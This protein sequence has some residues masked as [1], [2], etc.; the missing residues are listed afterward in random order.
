MIIDH[1]VMER[2]VAKLG[3]LFRNGNLNSSTDFTNRNQ[4]LNLWRNK[5]HLKDY[6]HAEHLRVKYII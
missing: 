2:Y 1:I 4:I 3:Q 6:I 5:I